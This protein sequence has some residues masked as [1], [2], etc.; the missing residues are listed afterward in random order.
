[1]W[2]R[3]A[4]SLRLEPSCP[5]TPLQPQ[6][7]HCLLHPCKLKL[8]PRN[9]LSHNKPSVK[10]Q[11][12]HLLQLSINNRHLQTCLPVMQIN[13][14]GMVRA[15]Q[16]LMIHSVSSPL[17]PR[18]PYPRHTS[19]SQDSFRPR[20]SRHPLLPMTILNTTVPTRVKLR[21]KRINNITV[22]DMVRA[23]KHSKD[24]VV[25]LSHRVRMYRVS[26]LQAVHNSR[27][28]V[29]RRLRIV[30]TTHPT[31]P[32]KATKPSIRVICRKVKQATDSMAM[33]IQMRTISNIRSTGDSMAPTT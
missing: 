6:E 13:T 4:K 15:R 21:L 29:N 18:Q 30:G 17:S 33:A 31:Q 1:M 24:Q 12:C 11:D 28:M 27:V 3:T 10:R 2:T 9:T 32:F 25:H 23:K 22:Q 14:H 8:Q 16:K 26:T 7:P 19:H 5:M 20:P